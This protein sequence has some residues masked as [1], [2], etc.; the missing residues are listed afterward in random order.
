MQHA[1]N[2]HTISFS[3]FL[4]LG[5]CTLGL[6]IPFPRLAW[7]LRVRTA[8]ARL[9]CTLSLPTLLSHLAVTQ[10]VSLAYTL[11]HLAC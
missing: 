5:S 3:T 8:L 11:S 9:D 1:H 2:N 7:T 6:R 10:L 4:T